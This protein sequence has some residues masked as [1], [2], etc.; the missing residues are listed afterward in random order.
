MIRTL[1]IALLLVLGGCKSQWPADADPALWVVRDADTTIY[2]F[3]TVHMLRPGMTWFDDGV[4]KAF[5]ASDELV[6]ELVMP[7]EAEMQALVAELGTTPGRPTLPE[8]LPPAAAA[9]FRAAL[10][11]MGMAPD[12]LDHAEPWLAATLLSSAPLR[13]LG[14]DD[15]DGAEQVLSAAAA[16]AGKPVI[17]LETA[18]QQLGYFDTLPLPAQRALLVRTLEE[19]PKA[20]EQIDAMV[21]AWS[22]GDPDALG[23]LMNED[24]DRSPELA[25]A[26][27]VNRNRNWAGWIQGR[28][29]KPGT[30]FVAVGAGHLAGGASVQAELAKRGLKAERVAE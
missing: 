14:Y 5:D 19:L 20:G 12:A 26:L 21:A 22:K 13:K 9:R 4:R 15:K 11:E 8:Q 27:L 7:P 3:G 16:Q 25:Q 30:V 18:R 24:L 6:L 2:L 29:E 23:A 1:L 17:G 28:M 10:V